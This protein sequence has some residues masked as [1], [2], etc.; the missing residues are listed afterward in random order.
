MTCTPRQINKIKTNIFFL[1][2]G[3]YDTY[4]EDGGGGG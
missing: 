3:T 1:I 4:G 2:G